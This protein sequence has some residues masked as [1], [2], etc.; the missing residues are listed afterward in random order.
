MYQQQFPEQPQ[1]EQLLYQWIAEWLQ[2][3]LATP[4]NGEFQLKQLMAQYLSECPFYLS[5]SDRVLVN[6]THTA[7]V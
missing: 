7:V 6:A 4:L 5:L 1:A 3:V 2:D